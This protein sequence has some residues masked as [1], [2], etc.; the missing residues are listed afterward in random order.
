M[1]LKCNATMISTRMWW[2]SA[3][4]DFCDSMSHKIF[5]NVKHLY[6]HTYINNNSNEGITFCNFWPL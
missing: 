3:C 5:A 2:L 1:K 6:T 4:L